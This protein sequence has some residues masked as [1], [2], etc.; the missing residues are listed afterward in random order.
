VHDEFYSAYDF[1]HGKADESKHMAA[2]S[3]II[4]RHTY[5]NFERQGIRAGEAPQ[6]LE[7]IRAYRSTH[8]LY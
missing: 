5:A 6:A 1:L 4:R 8:N 7:E 3:L 2:L